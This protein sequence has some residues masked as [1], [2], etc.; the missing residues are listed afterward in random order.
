MINAILILLVVTAVCT[1]MVKSKE[2][3]DKNKE[4]K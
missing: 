4:D 3:E 2:K 1:M